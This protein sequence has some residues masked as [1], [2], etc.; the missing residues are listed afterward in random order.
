MI[1]QR[2]IYTIPVQLLIVK[3]EEYRFPQSKE[4]CSFILSRGRWRSH[5]LGIGAEGITRKRI[6]WGAS[7]R[8]RS[9]RVSPDTRRPIQLA[10]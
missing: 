6:T 9:T 1:V 10:R 5:R 2:N 3:A 8:I 4:I 7:S